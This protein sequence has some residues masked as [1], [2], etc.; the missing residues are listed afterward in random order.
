M[1]HR[2]CCIPGIASSE[3]V[4]E[5]ETDYA[6]TDPQPPPS[7]AHLMQGIIPS[8]R[9]ADMNI[10]IFDLDDVQFL[11]KGEVLSDERIIR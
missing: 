4:A 1:V 3:S 7:G 9:R 10:W 2:A 11:S 5:V 8:E 6:E